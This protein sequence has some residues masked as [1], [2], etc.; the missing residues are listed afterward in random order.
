[1]QNE[2]APSACPVENAVS[3]KIE[4]ARSVIR[5]IIRVPPKRGTRARERGDVPHDLAR[6]VL[7]CFWY[8]FGRHLGDPA[9]TSDGPDPL[10]RLAAVVG[11][12]PT[13][14]PA[15]SSHRRRSARRR[16][17][18]MGGAAIFAPCSAPVF[19]FRP[20]AQVSPNF[21]TTTPRPLFTPVVFTFLVCW[22]WYDFQTAFFAPRYS[23]QAQRAPTRPDFPRLP[24][25][26]R[27]ARAWPALRDL[28]DL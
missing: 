13:Q 1:M 23:R 21:H 10:H 6:P 25:P 26:P 4:A 2:L 3:L 9:T 28:R 18:E 20:A 22:L 17:A 15:I 5:G 11:R 12:S 7:V 27:P 16:R 19:H 14:A 8:T 24:H